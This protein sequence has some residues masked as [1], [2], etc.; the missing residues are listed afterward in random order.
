[1]YRNCRASLNNIRNEV[2]HTALLQN[3]KEETD[4]GAE[5]T[6][7]NSNDLKFELNS[8]Q[9]NGN[10][11]KVCREDVATGSSV[12]DCKPIVSN[13]N[14]NSIGLQNPNFVDLTNIDTIT[15]PK[16]KDMSI[17]FI[18]LTTDAFYKAVEP[19]AEST[20]IASNWTSQVLTNCSPIAQATNVPR[21]G[22]ASEG[23]YN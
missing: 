11:V 14:G 21:N 18:D 2:M 16:P 23:K 7:L 4:S 9:C 1:M 5:E 22:P 19:I 12:I 8:P 17:P 3:V 20:K 13:P 6:T 10:Q 15:K